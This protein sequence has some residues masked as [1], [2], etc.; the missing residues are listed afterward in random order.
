MNLL[1]S[2]QLTLSMI[3]C[4]HWFRADNSVICE[5][6]RPACA[7]IFHVLSQ[8]TFY[9]I[10]F[11]SCQT[12]VRDRLFCSSV[13]KLEFLNIHRLIFLC[14]HL[15]FSLLSFISFVAIQHV[16]PLRPAAH[17]KKN[18]GI[19]S[20]PA[21]FYLGSQGSAGT[22]PSSLRAGEELENNN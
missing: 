17:S 4:H 14:R 22:Y 19:L 18:A 16:S 20:I 9:H 6:T 3:L 10:Y 12:L 13:A 11:H 2:D 21:Y 7:A 5:Q 1:L 15:I 8:I